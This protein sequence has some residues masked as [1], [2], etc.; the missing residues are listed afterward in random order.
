MTTNDEVNYIEQEISRPKT[1][2]L[3]DH[4]NNNGFSRIQALVITI[5]LSL[6]VGISI[7]YYMVR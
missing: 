4:K 7:A 3:E 5:I 2:V 6:I 1:R